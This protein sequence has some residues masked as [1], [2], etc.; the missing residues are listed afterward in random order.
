MCNG[1]LGPREP[2][3][4]VL[5]RTRFWTAKTRSKTAYSPSCKR[6]EPESQGAPV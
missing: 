5:Y 2:I 6:L 1:C 3:R 4:L